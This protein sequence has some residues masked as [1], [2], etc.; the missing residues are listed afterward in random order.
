[1]V[2]EAVLQTRASFAPPATLHNG[3]LFSDLARRDEPALGG[4][5]VVPRC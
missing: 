2:E 4:D 5:F 1:M 3:T